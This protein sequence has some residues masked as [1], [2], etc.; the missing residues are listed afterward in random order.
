MCRIYWMR[1]WCI[2]ELSHHGWIPY[3]KLVIKNIKSHQVKCTFTVQ[4]NIFFVSFVQQKQNN[5]KWCIY[6]SI[7]FW[8][9]WLNRIW[10]NQYLCKCRPKRENILKKD[11]RFFNISCP[12]LIHTTTSTFTYKSIN[13]NRLQRHIFSILKKVQLDQSFYYSVLLWTYD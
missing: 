11:M 6:A 4:D 2:S 13:L 1:N 12:I 7:Q 8:L 9:A 3:N 10:F 5:K